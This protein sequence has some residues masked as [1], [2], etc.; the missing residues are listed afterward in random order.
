ML[1]L[2]F[3]FVFCYLSHTTL[4]VDY[5]IARYLGTK[6]KSIILYERTYHTIGQGCVGRMPYVSVSPR[7]LIRRFTTL[8][9][10]LIFWYVSVCV[11]VFFFFCPYLFGAAVTHIGVSER[12][13]RGQREFFLHCNCEM[14]NNVT[15]KSWLDWFRT[16]DSNRSMYFSTYLHVTK[17][18]MPACRCSGGS[19]SALCSLT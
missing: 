6:P 18:K 15:S 8:C 10:T 17:H 2:R 13:S 12:T 4:V 19:H 11:R 9:T 14:V 5:T 3:C 16:C 7:Q 1:L